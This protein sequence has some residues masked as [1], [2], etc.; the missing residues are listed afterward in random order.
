MGTASAQWHAFVLVVK[1]TLLLLVRG[2]RPVSVLG[3]CLSVWCLLVL[4][5]GLSADVQEAESD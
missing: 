1:K 5:L 4:V 2:L 3:V